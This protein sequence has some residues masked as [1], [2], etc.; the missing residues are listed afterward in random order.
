MTFTAGSATATLSVATVD[1]ER[2]FLRRDLLGVLT[3]MP[4]RFRIALPELPSEHTY[5]DAG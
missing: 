5:I 2:Y 3:A 1:D 4:S